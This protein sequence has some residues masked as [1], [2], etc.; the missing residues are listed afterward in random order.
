MDT[1]AGGAGVFLKDSRVLDVKRE[2]STYFVINRY[3]FRRTV[4]PPPF[5]LTLFIHVLMRFNVSIALISINTNKKKRFAFPSENA[6]NVIF[7]TINF[8]INF[9]HNLNNVAGR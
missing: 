4:V 1:I 3:V 7:S 6:E 2:Y 5:I 8:A 9:K